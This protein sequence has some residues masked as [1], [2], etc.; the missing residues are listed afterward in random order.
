MGRGATISSG[1]NDGVQL[2]PTMPP[3]GSWHHIAVTFDGDTDTVLDLSGDGRDEEIRGGAV[4][5]TCAE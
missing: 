2:A 1:G 5:E 3:R 4:A